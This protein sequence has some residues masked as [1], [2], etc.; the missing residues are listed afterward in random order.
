MAAEQLQ[1][2]DK[3]NELFLIDGSGYIFRAYFA[4]P[5]NLTNPAG[6]P[7]GAVLGFCNMLYKLLND[8]QA[9]NIAVIFDA[10]KAN[11]RNDIYDEYKA[12]RPDAP[13]D[14]IP[15]FPLFRKAAEAFGLPAIE[16]EGYEADDLI[17]T[18]SKQAQEKGMNVTIV[19]SDKDLMQLINDHIKLF[20]PIKQAIIDAEA[21]EKKFGVKPEKMIDLQALTGDSVDNI[22]GVPS[23]GPKTAAQL[24]EEYD[25]LENL[26]DHLEEI[27]Q[28]KRREVLM[29]HADNAR[30]SKKLVTLAQ[31]APVPLSLDDMEVHDPKTPNLQAFLEEQG[32][33][34]L[35][36]RLGYGAEG[37]V[38]TVDNSSA[39]N[40]SH[41]NDDYPAISENSYELIDTEEQ[42]KEF[43]Q[44]VHEVGHL[45]FDTE[46]TH[47]TPRHAEIVGIAL[48]YEIGQAYYLPLSHKAEEQD[49]LGGGSDQEIKQIPLDTVI[50]HL[51]PLMEDPSILKIAH[52]AK[53]DVQI[54][55]DIGINVTPV[56]DTMLVSYVLDGSSHRHN[57]DALSE[58]NF[59]H[60]PIKFE[61]V[62]GKGKKQVTFDFVSL[63]KALDYAAEDADVTHRLYQVLKP[64]LAQEKMV[65]VYEDIERPLVPV[66]ADM[67]RQGVKVDPMTLKRFSD[68]FGK[69]L[70]NLEEDIHKLAGQQFNV[71]SPKQLGTILFDEMG[72]QGGKKTKTGDWSTDVSTLEK[73]ADAGEEIVV[74]VLEYRQLAKLKST[75]TDALQEVIHPQTKRVHTSYS[76]VGTSTGRLS[77]SDPNLQN[78]PIRTEQ[79]RKIRE[80]F[81]AE[82]GHLLLSIDYSQIELRLAAEM[83]G[84]EA[85]KQAFK[86][87]D[88]IHALTASQVFDVPMDEMTS[89]IR[90]RA[91]A[92]NFGIIYGI[93]GWGLAKQLGIEAS[94]ANE[95]IRAYL[96][97]FPELQNFMEEAKEEAR[98]YGYVK[99]AYGRKC[100]TPSI[101]DKNP[102]R[103]QG[104]ERAAI[105]A[106]L[107]GTAADIIKK[108]MIKLWH[109]QQNGELG[110]AKMLL[111]VH[112]ELIFEVPEGEVEQR[113]E[114]IKEM[115]E[116]VA[117][118]DVPLI[119]EAGWGKSWAEA[120]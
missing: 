49:L 50:K 2:T 81:V 34:T 89:E 85:L 105:N 11:F 69:Q 3:S 118:F 40:P 80:A 5:Q 117:S 88:D 26:L 104:A 21:V 8:L 111:Q 115:M 51:K 119:A 14:L 103:R 110:E 77:S 59:G 15:Q 6:Q 76:M 93:S 92:I 72:L 109:A 20:D 90:R 44:K 61:D 98:K 19:G 17:A 18:Y 113:A 39:S 106:P 96:A 37:S 94:E 120:H 78:I 107:Q 32:F 24:L 108:A 66:I 83:A 22:P 86:N 1:K 7:V 100:F 41:S 58:Q 84:I 4:L 54:F 45:V 38:S 71:A 47:L 60:A 57:M 30:M 74:K 35:L 29:E 46:T 64:R 55:A 102:M 56:D 42:L 53:Y 65:Q 12:H 25:T 10:A 75:Y 101:N 33:K 116:S 114:Q 112:D 27:K 52:N 43:I 70:I 79:G 31:D 67:E 9:E 87:G 82:E 91:K 68:D 97:R 63:D 48:S 36:T 28:P 95:F 16:L 99:T 23:I 73:L 13:E 62:A